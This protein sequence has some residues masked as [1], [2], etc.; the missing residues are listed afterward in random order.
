MLK[1]LAARLP[2]GV[3]D[4]LGR[5][6]LALS[7]EPWNSTSVA[8]FAEKSPLITDDFERIKSIPGWFNLDDCTHFH[9]IL[10]LQSKLGLGGDLLEIG[11]YHGRSAALLAGYLNEGEKLVVCDTFEAD[12]EDYYPDPAS[13]EILSQNVLRVNSQLDPARIEVNACE[14][15]DLD[16]G[17]GARFRFVHVDG[18]HSFESAIGDLRI[19]RDHVLPL[20]VVA[21]DDYMHIRWPEVTAAV[22]DFLAEQNDFQILADLNRRGAVGR[23]LYLIRSASKGSSAV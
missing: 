22:R 12:V 15:R 1:E 3:R 10:S 19:C 9:L 2:S 21:I 23:K 8:R 7:G 13:P 16:L 14:S 18:G 20:G 11:S 6:Y 17:P 5:I 4:R